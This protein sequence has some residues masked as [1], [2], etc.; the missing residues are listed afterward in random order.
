[1]TLSF[2][3]F[4]LRKTMNDFAD[5]FRSLTKRTTGFKLAKVVERYADGTYK[6]A[7]IASEAERRV[8]KTNPSEEYAVGSWVYV[9]SPTGGRSVIGA[10]D[11]ILSRA[12]ADQKGLSASVPDHIDEE[13]SVAVVTRIVPDP[14]VLEAGGASQAAAIYGAGLLAPTY[15]DPGITDASAP[16]V[17]PTRVDLELVAGGAVAPGRYALNVGSAR[18]PGAIRVN[19]AVLLLPEFRIDGA[20]LF[21]YPHD[22]DSVGL[23]PLTAGDF[24][25]LF[26]FPAWDGGQWRAG[27][28]LGWSEANRI[29][30]DDYMNAPDNMG[31]QPGSPLLTISLDARP[32]DG[33]TVLN[34]I[35]VPTAADVYVPATGNVVLSNAPIATGPSAGHRLFA[36]APTSDPSIAHSLFVHYRGN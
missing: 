8:S 9:G 2:F 27:P 26:M 28:G 7:D 16:V 4:Y 15:S 18:V 34:V 14:V 35:S 12:P 6:V 5:Y 22:P 17:T 3:L 19:A 20:I 24:A 29:Y 33:G 25:V 13:V 32:E 1:M 30:N 36:I 11:V 31:R 10:S 21:Q 23:R